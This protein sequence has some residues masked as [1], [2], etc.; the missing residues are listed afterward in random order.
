MAKIQTPATYDPAT[1]YET[2]VT[3]VVPA[4]GMKL[5]PAYVYL[6]LGSVLSELPSD[7]IASATVEVTPVW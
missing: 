1:Y 6:L 5:R 7:A 2:R 4:A 3:R